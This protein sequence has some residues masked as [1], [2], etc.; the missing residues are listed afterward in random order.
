[1]KEFKGKVAVITGAASG[2]GRA[3][4]ERCAEEG[5]TVVLTG[6]NEDTLI[7]AE[8]DIKSKGATT[9]VVRTDVSKAEAVESLAK[10]TLDT[11]GAVHLLCNN[12]GV[13]GG[14]TIWESTLADWKWTLDVN[15]WGV[16]YG[17][18]YFMPIMLKQNTESHIVN[19]AS[20]A[21]L[22]AGTSFGPYTVSK[23]AVISLSEVLYRQL[24]EKD[25]SNIG[26][27]VL[28]PGVV[29]TRI[30]DSDR[31][32]PTEL[33]NDAAVQQSV[34]NDPAVV[35]HRKLIDAVGM[36]PEQVADSV[37]HAIRERKF[38]VLTSAA[39]LFKPA[40]RA[41]MEDILK[42]RNP[43]LLRLGDEDA[44]ISGEASETQE[45]I[46]SIVWGFAE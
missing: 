11:F 33:K 4:A 5:M 30:M 8:K 36:P 43:T 1:M 41:R 2:I 15:L 25:I 6:P 3:L 42:E 45:Y 18:H 29:K 10:K 16:I 23:D 24:E 31:N 13:G 12:A 38:Y 37:F 19:T 34:D 20:V 32:R 44:A 39:P 14:L 27:S 7:A 17:I 28:C 21:G 26:V 9:L 22:L 46:E 35:G 40:I